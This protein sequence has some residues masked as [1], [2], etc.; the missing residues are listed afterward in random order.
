MMSILPNE[1]IAVWMSLSGASP[2]VRSPPKTA[3]S[4]LISPAACSATSAS[5]SLMTTFAPCSDRSSAVARPI[6][7]AEPVTIATL[8]SRT[9]MARHDSPWSDYLQSVRASDHVEHDLVGAGADPVQ[10]Q[11]APRALDLV[12][13]HVARP[14]VD[15]QAFVGHLAAHLG[16][17]ELG[18]RD[19]P[20]GFPAV[21]DPPRRRVA[22][23]AARLDLGRHRGELV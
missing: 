18:H 12:L 6:P 13:A 16:G 22:E 19:P 1:S 23:L 17:V 14:A 11:I 10:A 4:P 3:V 9:P 5:R 8:S 21:G 20:R 15:L 2:F 7:R